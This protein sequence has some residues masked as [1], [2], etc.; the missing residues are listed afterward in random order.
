[1]QNE[2]DGSLFMV[3][4]M[5]RRSHCT[6]ALD[7][8]QSFGPAKNGFL[9]DVD[10]GEPHATL[11]FLPFSTPTDQCI[12]GRS[13]CRA[14]RGHYVLAVLL[15]RLRKNTPTNTWFYNLFQ[16]RARR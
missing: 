7:T 5:Q 6:S 13:A 16:S 3:H 2:P 14:V 9:L 11:R 15:L 12:G 4:L 8:A 1:M 10:K